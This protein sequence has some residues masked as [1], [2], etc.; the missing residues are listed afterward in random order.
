[1]VANA[2]PHDGMT[3]SLAA[4]APSVPFAAASSGLIVS[5]VRTRAQFDVLEA[6]WNALFA[7]CAKGAHVFQSFNWNWHWANVYLAEADNSLAL[8]ALYR[9]DRL[10]A[11]WPLQE[12]RLLGARVLEWMGAPVSQY[13]DILIDPDEDA[14][15][16]L[17]CG[18]RTITQDLRVDALHLRKVRADANVLPLLQT[19]R[20]RIASRSEAPFLDIASAPDL[21]TYETRYSSK[22]RKNRRRLARRLAEAGAMRIERLAD[23]PDAAEAARATV[24][25]RR[26][27]LHAT[28]RVSP[29]L[30][31][32]RYARFFAEATS[33]TKPCGCRVTRILIDGKLVASAIDVTQHGARAA[34]MIAHDLQYEACGPGV[35]MVGDWVQ[36]AFEDGIGV[37]DL[38]APAHSYKWDWADS[39]VDVADH[40]VATSWIG[41]SMVVPYLIEVR[42]RLKNAWEQLAQWRAGRQARGDRAPACDGRAEANG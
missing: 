14:R 21:A 38:L 42:P 41:R 32:A 17:E 24:L 28:G 10:V 39:S 9:G 4:G 11:L 33:G 31:D 27:T 19:Q 5:I 22:T 29:A 1:M 25:L 37:L 18:W 2:S 34:H 12:A 23:G 13:G 6:D 30:D 3:G 36:A 15:A 26:A 7:R 20:S 35:T 40:V 8:I 16:V